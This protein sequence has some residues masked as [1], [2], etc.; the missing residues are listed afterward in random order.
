MTT[1]QTGPVDLAALR[2]QLTGSAL[3]PNDPGWG[4]EVSGF[5]SAVTHRPAVVV[6]ASDASDVQA[7]VRYAAGNGLSVGVQATGHGANV[8]MTGGLLVNTRRLDGARVDPET[9]VATVRAGTPWRQVIRAA[10]P[11]GLA[12]LSGSSSGVGAVGYMVGGGVPVIGR[13]FGYAADYVTGLDVVTADGRLHR[14]DADSEPELYWGL[15][16]G[17]GSLGIVTAMTMGLVP[18]ATVYGGGIFYAAEH[19][20]T[21]L[22]AWQAWCGDLPESVTTSVA[23]VR[24]PPA[25]ELPEPLRGQTV[26]HL[27]F[28]HIG[29]A[30]D[31]ASLVAPMR[32]A[33]PALL[34]SI[35]ELPYTAIDAVHQDP[36]HPVPVCQRGVALRDCTSETIAALLTVAGPDVRTPLMLC[37][38]RQLGGALS[39]PPAGGSA[40]GG[41]ESAFSLSAVSMLTPET[42]TV[43]P[44][45][46]DRLLAAAAPWATGHTLLNLHGA[47]RDDADRARPWDAATYQRLRELRARVDPSGLFCFGHPVG[48]RAA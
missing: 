10:A 27:R 38:I 14:V 33:A 44:A 30:A 31:G 2:A 22:D 7:A 24:L 25:P 37:E 29:S 1:M 21:A 12:P 45:A 48:D 32:S 8:P 46:V 13:T 19:I 41:R 6:A 9:R 40:V 11:Y 16:G 34:D 18:V 4:A 23:I 3:L 26:A 5:N 42:A 43:A 28:C 39:R 36:D 47:P 15:R 17:G 20:A 35:T